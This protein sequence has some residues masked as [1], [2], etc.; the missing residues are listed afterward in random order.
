MSKKIINIIIGFILA[1]LETLMTTFLTD[2]INVSKIKFLLISA[3]IF[4]II[5]IVYYKFKII[6]NYFSRIYKSLFFYYEIKEIDGCYGRDDVIKEIYE[7]HI[8]TKNIKCILL[9]GYGGAGKSTIIE[10][11]HKVLMSRTKMI[12][13][14]SDLS[15]KNIKSNSII[16]CDYALENKN[17]I[18]N[19]IQKIKEK[20]KKRIT[21]VLIER[22]VAVSILET[23]VSFD[24]IIDLNNSKYTLSNEVL[25]SILN[26]NIT[27]NYD[28]KNRKYEKNSF[29]VSDDRL[30]ELVN[31]ITKKYD[32]KLKRPIFCVILASIYKENT[33]VDFSIQKNVD[34]LFNRYWDCITRKNKINA[35]INSISED[36]SFSDIYK[37]AVNDNCNRL[38]ME[39][40][41]LTIVSSMTLLSFELDYRDDGIN[42]KIYNEQYSDVTIEFPYIKKC[43]ED[44]LTSFGYFKL[45]KHLVPLFLL[46]DFAQNN[47][48]GYYAIKPIRY[49]IVAAWLFSKLISC[50]DE[51]KWFE[52]IIKTICLNYHDLMHNMFNFSIRAADE[53]F[54]SALIWFSKNIKIYNQYTFNDFKKDIDICLQEMYS[55][56]NKNKDKYDACKVVLSNLFDVIYSNE[57]LM[58]Y[59]RET[60]RAILSNAIDSNIDI[61]IEI[62][63][64]LQEIINIYNNEQ[65]TMIM[66]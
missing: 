13:Y 48:N 42:L 57:T 14:S 30:K 61:D 39:I 33:N 53:N 9:C 35:F 31:L 56:Y 3:P 40:N 37:I 49:D 65:N 15:I 19:L 59:E 7:T 43:I 26:Y 36:K 41:C 24:K 1:I 34:M 45:K 23:K 52:E 62:K 55:T 16:F 51:R 18:S 2:L 17:E 66:R 54:S 50:D 21:F 25:K 28:E 38:K 64:Y 12:I 29:F 10:N 22:N 6:I 32:P 60:L 20:Q 4:I 47:L 8:S 5:Y 44:Y 46:N 11:F 58:E 63:D 27:H